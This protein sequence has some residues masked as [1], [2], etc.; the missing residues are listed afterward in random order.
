MN[1]RKRCLDCSS[2]LTPIYTDLFDTRF[3]IRGYYAASR[4]DTCGLVQLSPLPSQDELKDL[5]ETHYN[6]GGEHDTTYT[7]LRHRFLFSPIYR[8]W[9]AIDGDFSFHTIQGAGHLLDV[10]CNEGRGL[11]FYRRNGWDAEGQELNEN[12]ANVARRMGF[13]VHTTLIENFYPTKLYDVVVLSNV[14]EHSLNPRQMLTNVHRLLKP[15]GQIWI[16]CPNIKSLFR[17]VFGRYWINWHVP[18]H[19]VQFSYSTLDNILKE[20]GFECSTIRYVTPGLWVAHSIISFLFA[21]PGAPTTQLRKTLWIILLLGIA[22]GIFFPLLWAANHLGRGD[23]LI[24]TAKKY[25]CES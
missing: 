15:G 19:T 5:Y 17:N 4:C 16:S 23:C 1:V 20:S 13:V 25:S 9:T 12:A 21:K 8:L 14:L 24:A 11:Q 18:F 2:T 7:S 6:F 22:R 10:G 3:G